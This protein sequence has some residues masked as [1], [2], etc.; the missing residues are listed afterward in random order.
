MASAAH[1]RCGADAADLP[2]EPVIQQ[3]VGYLEPLAARLEPTPEGGPSKCR[4]AF[5]SSSSHFKDSCS[6]G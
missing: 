3:V 2:L 4:D 5:E 1:I 6:C